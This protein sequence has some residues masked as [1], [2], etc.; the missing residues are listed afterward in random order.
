MEEK[1][2]QFRLLN[3]RFTDVG[4]KLNAEKGGELQIKFE[5]KMEVSEEKKKMRFELKTS[6]TDQ[7]GL[8]DLYATVVALFEFDTELTED[9]KNLFF[10]CNA[11]AIIFPFVRAFISTMTA[12]AGNN[13]LLPT[14]NFSKK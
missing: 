14:I 10:E 5:R 7:K 3:H 6:I 8:V 9:Q 13:I 12:L 11:P 2:A 1:I 4:M